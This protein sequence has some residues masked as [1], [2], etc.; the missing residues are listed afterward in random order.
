MSLFRE[1]PHIW[2]HRSGERIHQLAADIPMAQPREP[3]SWGD[4]PDPFPQA[5]VFSPGTLRGVVALNQTESIDDVTVALTS[6]ERYQNGARLRYLAHT[7]DPKKRKPLG[8]L[9][10]LVVDDQG[11]R[12]RTALVDVEREGNRVE[13]SLAIAPAIPRDTVHLTVT[14]GTMGERGSHDGL[15]GPWVFPI[16]LP[17]Q[18][19]A[20]A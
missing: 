7:S 16:Q 19:P 14:I 2:K 12:Y 15:P 5:L 17:A 4:V 6:L 20:L 11:R 9:D 8:A 3:E 10:V 18:A 1:R 13:G